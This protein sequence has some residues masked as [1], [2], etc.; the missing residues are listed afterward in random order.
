MEYAKEGGHHPSLPGGSADSLST[1]HYNEMFNIAGREQVEVLEI[2][3]QQ[4]E[5]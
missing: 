1:D 3:R 5:D 4:A 2:R